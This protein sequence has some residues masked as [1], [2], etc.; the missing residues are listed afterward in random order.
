MHKSRSEYR[1][2]YKAHIAIEPETGLITAAALT[3]ANTPDGSTGVN[4]LVGEVSGLQILGDGAYGSGPT[5][6]ALGKAK[7]HLAI[8][9]FPTTS[10]VKGGFHRDDFTVDYE[11]RTAT[12]PAAYTVPITPHGWAHFGSRCKGCRFRTRC[13]KS[14]GGKTLA[15][16]ANDAELVESRRAWRA[17]DFMKDYRQWR[18]MVERSI[19]WLVADNHR[20]VRFRGVE[21]NHLGLSM[22]V[23]AINLRRLVNLGLC[24]HGEWQVRAV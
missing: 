8:K 10:A 14:K 16:T 17:G 21:K 22:R 18:P 7:H 20:R 12:C 11:A 19:A 9:P 3:P 4:L 15:L 2:G 23:A 13:T 1:D 6:H 24:H 5:L